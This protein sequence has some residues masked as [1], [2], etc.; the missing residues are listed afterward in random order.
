MIA[1]EYA[2]LAF[3]GY[4]VQACWLELKDIE[5]LLTSQCALLADMKS[6]RYP[7]TEQDQEECLAQIEEINK[8]YDRY[9]Y[10]ISC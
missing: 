4:E 3:L 5:L 9:N 1:Q 2:Y 10:Q 7:S 8:N 6:Q